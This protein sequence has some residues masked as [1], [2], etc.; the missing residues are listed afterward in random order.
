M[1]ATIATLFMNMYS[2]GS[3]FVLGFTVLLSGTFALVVSLVLA[4]IVGDVRVTL[5][6]LLE[7][8]PFLVVTIGFERPFVLSKAII[9]ASGASVRDK[10]MKGLCRALPAF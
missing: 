7:C 8:L 3:R 1:Y 4:R 10:V 5:I 9:E 6:V 2:I